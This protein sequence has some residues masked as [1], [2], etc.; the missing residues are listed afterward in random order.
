M[1]V[2]AVCDDSHE[3]LP[4]FEQV[5]GKIDE[6]DE[7]KVDERVHDLDEGDPTDDLVECLAHLLAAA[8][9]AAASTANK[10][11]IQHIKRFKEE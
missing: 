4:F 9:Q 11:L 3:E 5:H 1:T 10:C 8:L 2:D 7:G 6:S